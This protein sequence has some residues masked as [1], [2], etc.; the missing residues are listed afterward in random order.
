MTD[1][2]PRQWTLGEE[3]AHSITH[4]VG[5]ALAVVAFVV[6][7]MLA[8]ARGD[9]WHLAGCIVFGATLVLLYTAS[10]LYHSIPHARAKAIFQALDHIAIYLL[11]AGSY[12]P[13]TLVNL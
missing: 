11:I 1:A 5:A 10:T 12:T 8:Y 7:T 4:G 13:F 9:G 2:S 3:I 6:L